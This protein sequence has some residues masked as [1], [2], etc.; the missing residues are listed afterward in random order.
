ML[1]LTTFFALLAVFLFFGTNAQALTIAPAATTGD[2]TSFDDGDSGGTQSATSGSAASLPDEAAQSATVTGYYDYQVWGDTWG[3]NHDQ[4]YTHQLTTVF[5]VLADPTVDYDIVFSTSRLGA[6]G[7]AD[8]TWN[9]S[10]VYSSAH[11]G[12]L[13]G[14]INAGSN[15]AGLGLTGQAINPSG[16]SLSS[17]QNDAV[18]QASTGTTVTGSG[19]STW[20]VIT[21]WTSR[22]TSNYDESGL[23]FGDDLELEELA[24]PAGPNDG[25]DTH[26]SLTITAVPEPST[27]LLVGLGLA[28]F[29]SLKRKR[30]QR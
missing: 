29:A 30:I 11:L 9:N 12:V 13:T 16:S 22:V 18:N 6:I 1:K 26:A 20:T 10:T 24:I 15:E 23:S 19:N 21:T 3:G 7:I 25:V 4:T 28:G 17:D 2:S 14:T 8:D 27:A 5:T